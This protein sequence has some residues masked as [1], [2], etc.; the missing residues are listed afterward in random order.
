[1]YRGEE[2]GMQA[3]LKCLLVFAVLIAALTACDFSS[4][5][6]SV[7]VGGD[8]P[9]V[10]VKRPQAVIINPTDNNPV[11][12]FSDLYFRDVSSPVST[13][14]NL[15][16]ELTLGKG[17]VADP[18][19]SFD[20]KQ[21]IFSMKCSVDSSAACNADTTWNIW[22]YNIDTQSFR[23]VMEFF[24]ANE[25]DD[26][27]PAFLPN[28]KIVFSSTRQKS[29]LE[30][31]GYVFTDEQ[32]RLP[33]SVLH[34]MRDDGTNI[35]QIS[36]NRGNDRNPTVLRNGK[37]I[38]SRWQFSDDSNQLAIYSANP[39]GS[40]M[41]VMYGAHSPGEAFLHPRELPDGKII[42]TVLPIEG[43]WES[44]ALMTLDVENYSD[45][46]EPA[47]QVSDKTTSGQVS[48]TIQQIPLDKSVSIL[49]RFTTPYPLMDGSNQ[50]LVSFSFFQ[51]LTGD[52]SVLDQLNSIDDREAPP[53]FGIYILNT[54]DKSLKPLVLAEDDKSMTDPIAIFPRTE[55][56]VI[57]RSITLNPGVFDPNQ[58]EGILN[59]KS[60][61]DTDHFGRMGQ[62]VLTAQENALT[63][64]P[65]ITPANPDLDTRQFIADIARLKDPMQT[66]ADQRPARFVRISQALPIP[67]EFTVQPLSETEFVL[68]KIVGYAPVE[69]DGSVKIKV[70]ADVPISISVLDKYGRAYENHSNWIQVRPGETLTCHGC[71]APSKNT[72]LNSAPI[73]GFHSNT[74]L[75]STTG[76]I[77]SGGAELDE[78]MAET[79][80]RV[81]ESA[82]ELS[83]NVIY[84]DVW[85]DSAQRAVDPEINYLYENLSTEF[86]TDG[87]ID[88]PTHI[89]PIWSLERTINGQ[90][91]PCNFCHNGIEDSQRNPTSFDLNGFVGAGK[92][93]SYNS[94]L[95]G[96]VLLDSSGQP[97]LEKFGNT[98]VVRRA[99]PLVNA[100]YARGSYLV[101]KI[102]G[103]EL[104]ADKALPVN[105]L[106]HSAMLTDDEKRLITEWIDGGAQYCNDPFDED[107][108]CEG[109]DPLPVLAVFASF[110]TELI[111]A[112]GGCHATKTV[113]GSDNSV[114]INSRFV[115]L[116][117]VESDFFVSLS[118]V[119]DRIDPDKSYILARPS[120]NMNDDKHWVDVEKTIPILPV[121]S[122]LYL[123]IKDWISGIAN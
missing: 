49:G 59:I 72:A 71:H 114:F 122:D 45:A 60:V 77:L 112:C 33:V 37:I 95:V 24:E 47:P 34:T 5:S 1:M 100:G 43:T 11:T 76:Q 42:T 99:P 111:Q 58:V 69:P 107:G 94:L 85:T 8:F 115:L 83:L 3:I 54:S 13:E 86:P 30:K 120:G 93:P 35:E 101:E 46:N 91:Q 17:D 39:D 78:T 57:Q 7:I 90:N 21:I 44:G 23:R 75:K 79:R 4:K 65:L 88:Y 84:K 102:F 6:D 104:F 31:H 29:I 14:K 62:G 55:P 41:D 123:A 28:N 106:D 20:G 92:M 27:D 67:E 110:H 48:S 25:A 36:F 97:L 32:Q 117:E 2:D 12:A 87:L 10:Y 38:F 16:Q 66:T 40:D 96:Q 61:Y 63:P 74:Q 52:E 80:T 64:F 9:I 105:G 50:V 98:E 19:V 15:T 26:V 18:E 81:D 103:A 68:Q 109:V 118:M 116:R 53:A 73:A 121:G 89:Q 70:P 119:S 82:L 113:S 108:S 22:I 51:K 56:P